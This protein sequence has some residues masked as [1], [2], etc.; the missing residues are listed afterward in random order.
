MICTGKGEVRGLLSNKT[1]E[2]IPL[3]EAI[4]KGAVQV[5][6]NH[7]DW[8]YPYNGVTEIRY[9]DIERDV[10]VYLA[11]SEQRSCALAAATDMMGVMCRAAGGY[12]VEQLPGAQPETI[13]KVEK[14]LANLMEEDGSSNTPTGLLIKGFTP[15]DIASMILEG[16]DMKPLQQLKPVF[17]CGC[18]EERML[19]VVRLMPREEVEEILEKE[20]QIE[21]RCQFCQ[22]VYR[23][24]AEEVRER[25]DKAVGDPSKDSDLPF[26]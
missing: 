3:P 4:G 17:S 21:A 2:D 22:T 18:S 12:M 25:L 19:R 9:G 13:A 8:P 5:V 24:P 16:L 14:N 26:Q 11:E 10:G 7:P 20:N 1:L 6:K 23:I 15:V